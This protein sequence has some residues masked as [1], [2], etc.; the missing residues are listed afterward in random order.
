MVV[1]NV[2]D[3]LEKPCV[4]HQELARYFARLPGLLHAIRH[5]GDR[6]KTWEGLHQ[7]KNSTIE[8]LVQDWNSQVI[9]GEL[10]R[11]GK[12]T[13]KFPKVGHLILSSHLLTLQEVPNLRLNGN[14]ETLTAAF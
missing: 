12:Q 14:V 8:G 11:H 1:V 5:L 7:P 9:P 4:E 13:N 10:I 3:V 6:S 2:S